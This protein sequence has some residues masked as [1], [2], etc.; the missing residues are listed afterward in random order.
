[1]NQTMSTF[2]ANP[3]LEDDVPSLGGPSNGLASHRAEH[4]A[5]NPPATT[6]ILVVDDSAVFCAFLR[7]S[8]QAAGYIVHTASDGQAA[9]DVFREVPIDL[10]ITDLQMPNMDGYTLCS[11]VRAS[12][13]VPI[14]ILSS[15]SEADELMLGFSAGANEYLTKPFQF[16]ELEERMERSLRRTA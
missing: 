9:L 4:T 12:S 13:D 10:I 2:A 1:M 11:Q 6:Q 5:A 16:G 7:S 8:L 15:S 14:I 3:L